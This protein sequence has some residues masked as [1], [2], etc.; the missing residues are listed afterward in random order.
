[1]YVYDHGGEFPGQLTIN[2]DKRSGLIVFMSLALENVS[3]ETVLKRFGKDY[4]LTKYEF[5]PDFDDSDAAP[6]F[7]SNEG[8]LTFI[9]YRSRG[10]AILVNDS[11]LAS[12]I[13]YRKSLVVI[14]HNVNVQGHKLPVT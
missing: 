5:C 1:M 7:E 6:I 2:V 9:E 8:G 11:D 12:E 13:S 14:A 4:V 3:K 10:L